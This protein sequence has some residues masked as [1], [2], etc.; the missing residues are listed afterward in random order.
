MGAALKVVDSLSF[1]WSSPIHFNDPFDHQTGFRFTFTGKELAT[2]LHRIFVSVANNEREFNPEYPTSFG[3]VL[4]YLA[5]VPISERLDSFLA[6]VEPAL[7]ELESTFEKACDQLNREL[8]QHHNHSRVFCVSES[9][10]SAAMW[11]HYADNH[12]LRLCALWN[13]A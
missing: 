12:F 9:N 1:R 7:H 3:T 8:I 6:E 10:D 2:E 4:S 13:A 11:A 5:N